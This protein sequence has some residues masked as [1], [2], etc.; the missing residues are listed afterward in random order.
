MAIS[1]S[2]IYQQ[3]SKPPAKKKRKKLSIKKTKGSKKNG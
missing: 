3:V 1:R 2:S